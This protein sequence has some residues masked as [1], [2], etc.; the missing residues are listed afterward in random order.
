V[1]DLKLTCPYGATLK[2]TNPALRG[3][4]LKCP[5]CSAPILVPADAPAG[6]PTP[7]RQRVASAPPALPTPADPFADLHGQPATPAPAR[8]RGKQ[9]SSLPLILGL[10]AGVA[11]LGLLGVGGLVVGYFWMQGKPA[12]QPVA[13]G[14][15][16]K[17]P[18]TPA[19]GPGEVV[20]PGGNP[21]PET[22]VPGGKEPAGILVAVDEAAR[23]DFQ[24]A[25][26]G[27]TI[28]VVGVYEGE[29]VLGSARWYR[30]YR[31]SIPAPALARESA[32]D[33]AVADRKY[34]GKALVV[35][36]VLAKVGREE[37]TLSGTKTPG[38]PA[39][40][41][42]RKP[43]PGRLL[44]RE[45]DFVLKPEAFLAEF[46][47]DGQAAR[48]K[49]TGKVIEMAGPIR[50]FGETRERIPL[51][52]LGKTEIIDYVTCRM[53]EEE[54]WATLAIGQQVRLRGK[55][56]P[57]GP[58]LEGCV[59]AEKGPNPAVRVT[60]EQLAAECAADPDATTKKYRGKP[61]LITGE[62][63][64]REEE[65]GS[66]KIVLKG[67]ERVCVSFSFV[68]S[69]HLADDIM[70]GMKVKAAGRF[71]FAEKAEV[72]LGEGFFIFGPEPKEPGPAKGPGATPKEE[73]KPGPG[74]ASSYLQ[75]TGQDHVALAGSKVL[76][77]LN[78]PFTI[79]LWVRWDPKEKGPLC[80][81]GD[82]AWPDMNP[83][84]PVRST[85]GWVLRLLGEPGSRRLDFNAGAR[86]AGKPE[87]A[88]QGLKVP[89]GEESAEWQ[90]IAVCRSPEEVRLYRNGK[91][92]GKRSVKGVLFVPAPTDLYLGIRANAYMTRRV[93]AGYR[94]FR[95]ASEA[96]YTGE[97][98]PPAEF[99]PSP[100]DLVVL[101]FTTGTLTDR[102]GKGHDGR[103]AG[104]KWQKEPAVTV[105]AGGPACPPP[106]SGPAPGKPKAKVAAIEVQVIG[107][108]QFAG[109]KLGDTIKVIAECAG[110]EEGKLILESGRRYRGY[111][112]SRLAPELAREYA[113]DPAAAERKYRGK[114]F[115]VEGVLTAMDRYV[116]NLS[117]TKPPAPS[118]PGARKSDP[119]KELLKRKLDFSVTLDAFRA[120][121]RRDAKAGRQKYG[122][123]VVDLSGVVR[124]FRRSYAEAPAV[125]VGGKTDSVGIVC[126]TL[127]EEPW[128]RLAEGQTVRMRGTFTPYPDFTEF[129]NCVIVDSGPSPAIATTAEA[130]AA[131]YAADPD[132][133]NKKHQ[134]KRLLITG[135]VTSREVDKEGT[136]KIALKGKEGVRVAM[137]FTA[138]I[139]DDRA[140]EE[141]KVGMKVRALAFYR[142]TARNEIHLYNVLFIY[143]PEPSAKPTNPP[144]GKPATPGKK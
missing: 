94:A 43:D 42:P 62:V 63:I 127:D 83:A 26:V 28:Q 139:T 47:R 49:D 140:D 58:M 11:V 93:S 129:L 81:A 52:L 109:Y 91:L 33:P 25:K 116:V 104:G 144:G 82:V 2:V 66:V 64:A 128:A 34:R 117:P 41:G 1:S 95:A 57:L 89:W 103:L 30:G 17:K 87:G 111:R 143:G 48:A 55:G 124:E 44:G 14:T 105:V 100:G 37:L 76:V 107:D 60:A 18:P 110:L 113:A 69:R 61:L 85:C 59:V 73:G 126:E 90:H 31:P 71:S 23:A 101:D 72:E 97:F 74:K 99:R 39:T 35:A 20:G 108:E 136:I 118:A 79:E 141:V 10:V 9:K 32:A 29:L 121:L 56:S 65:V 114:A 123:K 15:P 38:P 78:S 75:L 92:L 115:V 40:P 133:T 3:K 51:V 22:P 45:P 134:K 138:G 120:E 21:G 98:T 50:T 106:R 135:E 122:G 137:T 46:D 67:N 8:Q 88:W 77:R 53:A 27:D 119:G 12:P 80:L 131:A 4:K 7:A 70:V 24:G 125:R 84:L 96:R 102:T 5:R 6:K 13:G 112:P 86:A 132:G 19:E 142:S 54:P 16:V 130:L 68:V 36:G